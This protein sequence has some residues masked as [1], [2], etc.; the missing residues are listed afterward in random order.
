HRRPT[1]RR[2]IR[3][4]KSHGYFLRRFSNGDNWRRPRLCKP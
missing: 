2:H 4:S 1:K 3:D